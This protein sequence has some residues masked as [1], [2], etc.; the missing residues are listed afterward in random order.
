MLWQ[1]MWL[2][3]HGNKIRFVL[4]D[5]GASIHSMG[6]SCSRAMAR[7]RRSRSDTLHNFATLDSGTSNTLGGLSF[8]RTYLY[9]LLRT[10]SAP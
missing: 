1:L 9:G 10:P 5:Q 2:R 6:L 4:G 3:L 8:R 7:G